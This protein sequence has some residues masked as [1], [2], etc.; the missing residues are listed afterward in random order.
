[1]IS[2]SKAISGLFGAPVV[3]FCYFQRLK[4]FGVMPAEAATDLPCS[5]QVGASTLTQVLVGLHSFATALQ[6]A[7]SSRCNFDSACSTE[8]MPYWPPTAKVASPSCL[9]LDQREFNCCWGYLKPVGHL[10]G[11]LCLRLKPWTPFRAPGCSFIS[12]LE[13]TPKH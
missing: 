9:V 13:L 3:P 1:M 6:H 11:L 12:R 5:S 8:S 7:Q 2:A 4:H 10:S